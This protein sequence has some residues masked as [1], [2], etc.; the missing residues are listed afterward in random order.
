LQNEFEITEEAVALIPAKKAYERNLVPIKIE[1]NFLF[2]GLPNKN[3]LKIINDISFYTGYKIKVI[4]L[5]T[6]IILQKLKEIYKY[7]ETQK[8]SEEELI[9][10]N[11]ISECSNIEYVN[12]IIAG[13]I[14][15]LASDIHFECFENIF[16]V[17][18]RIDGHLREIS[19]L[20]KE[21]SLSVASRIK[22][23]ANLDI[24][25]KRRPQDGKIRF[26]FQSTMIDIREY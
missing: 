9:A 21:K 16:R 23:M 4:E 10:D 6:D 13:A 12:Q 5:P 26:S 11:F 24:S 14:K 15:S 18:Y 20:P 25:E 3:D 19:N 1:D 22:I 2:I 17:R 7:P 8:H